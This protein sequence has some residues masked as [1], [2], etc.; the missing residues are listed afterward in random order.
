MDETP[1]TPFSIPEHGSKTGSNSN[2]EGAGRGRENIEKKNPCTQKKRGKNGK[3]TNKRQGAQVEGIG[4][5]EYRRKSQ[6]KISLPHSRYVIAGEN[7]R[8][9]HVHQQSISETLFGGIASM[10]DLYI[11]CTGTTADRS[12]SRANLTAASAPSPSAGASNR[13]SASCLEQTDV[14]TLELRW[15]YMGGR[16]LLAKDKYEGDR[17]RQ[18]GSSSHRNARI[19]AAK[20][21]GSEM[22]W[23]YRIRGAFPAGPFPGNIGIILQL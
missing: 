20:Q 15:L 23:T 17:A 8:K 3:K 4:P 12:S 10:Q 7:K 16:G 14:F 13:A 2:F 22:H 21:H 11:G 1:F 6:T 5:D 18:K 19:W 9:S